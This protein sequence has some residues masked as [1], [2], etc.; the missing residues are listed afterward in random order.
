MS[1][2]FDLII[3]TDCRNQVAE[4]FLQSAVGSCI[5]THFVDFNTFSSSEQRS[6]FDLHDFLRH[7][8]DTSEQ[9]AALRRVGVCIAQRVLGEA[10]FA[11]LWQAEMPCALRIVLPS[12]HLAEN[13]LARAL[14]CLP[15]ELARASSEL[16]SLG[17]RNVHLSVAYSSDVT[18]H[19]VS[20]CVPDALPLPVIKLAPTE[21]LRILFVC[22][23]SHTQQQL[24]MRR[25]RMALQALF[26][27]QI[28]QRYMVQA[29]FLN[30]GL[31]YASLTAQL[32][33]NQGYHIIHWS[34]HGSS[35][36]LHLSKRNGAPDTLSGPELLTL[37]RLA[38]APLP[39]LFF[40]SACNSARL[41]MVHNW[42]GFTAALQ[43]K[44]IQAAAA[45]T[46]DSMPVHHLTGLAHTLLQAG[47]PSV[48]A[49][50][51][52]VGDV[53]LREWSLAFYDHLFG[54]GWPHPC[55]LAA[56][57]A[58]ARTI[59]L[60]EDILPAQHFVCDSVC[61]LLFGQATLSLDLTS[62]EAQARLLPNQ[63][64]HQIAELEATAHPYFIGRTRELSKLNSD[65]FDNRNASKNPAVL[66]LT[67]LGGMGKT[68][69]V[70]E[71]L[72]LW[73]NRFAA[74]LLYQGKP[75]ALSFEACLQDIHLKLLE[76]RPAYQAH[77][78]A[79]P[80]DAVY[81]AAPVALD[82]QSWREQRVAALIRA[83]R[84]EPILLLF[85]NF[86]SNLQA[87]SVASSLGALSADDSELDTK[88]QWTCADP[89]WDGGLLL[90][91]KELKGSPSK[92]IITSRQPPA[93]L[94]QSTK[95][96]HHILLGPLAANEAA[97]YLRE[98]PA[99][100]QM[101]MGGSADNQALAF[102]LLNASR[103]HPLLMDRFA[104]L[105]NLQ[106]NQALRDLLATLEAG[107]NFNLLPSLFLSEKGKRSALELAYLADAL[108]LSID[109][110][111]D[112]VS[113]DARRLLWLIALARQ[114]VPSSMLASVWC[115]KESQYRQIL[116]KINK[117][118]LVLPHLPAEKQA[119]VPPVS[120]DMRRELATLPPEPITRLAPT[121]LLFNLLTLGLA[122]Q[123]DNLAPSATS[124]DG[125]ISCHEL[126]RERILAWMVQH[127]A[128]REQFDEISV[129]QMWAEHL[130]DIFQSLRHQQPLAA[131]SAGSQAIE[132]CIA[133]GDFERMTD[134]AGQ[135]IT[136]ASEPRWLHRLLPHM[137][138]A[139]EAAP[140]GPLRW[141]CLGLL[142]DALRGAGKTDAS[143]PLYR[144]AIQFAR[145]ASQSDALTVDTR[146]EMAQA[147][148]DLGWLCTNAAAAARRCGDLTQARQ[149]YLDS[150]RAKQY[151]ARPTI[152]CIGTELEV[153]RID[154][155]Q[156][157]LSE[158]GMELARLL[159]QITAWWQ[160]LRSGIVVPQAPSIEVLA[161][162]LISALDIA[163][164]LD[165]AR[166]DWESALQHI[167]SILEI[168]QIMQRTAFDLAL[169]KLN[170]A[171][172]LI[173][174]QHYAQAR[175]DLETC[176]EQ[177]R[178][179]LPRRAKALGILAN[180]F[181]E[182][183]DFAQAIIQ[184]R[185]AAL[186]C[187]QLPSPAEHATAHYNLALY[188]ANSSDLGEQE[189]A[190]LHQ[191]AAL[192]YQYVGEMEQAR[193]TSLD[194]Y[195]LQFQQAHQANLALSVPRLAQ[196]L[197]LADCA[198]LRD[199][200]Q[201]H[202]LDLGELQDTLDQLLADVLRQ[203]IDLYTTHKAN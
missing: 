131:L 23:E 52:A 114:P 197:A 185:R 140:T 64:L 119:L 186:L 133:A 192:V 103:F 66:L 125:L 182:Q 181:Y 37:F 30:H 31:T 173:H 195:G 179:D 96:C 36:L 124:V 198:A 54:I 172:V 60:D 180:L 97:L 72:S 42:Q 129:Y 102:R 154:I 141:R 170:R 9:V 142:A 40:L 147:W 184:Q 109:H 15:W 167:Q 41:G 138:R 20:I 193:Q 63:R 76:N 120:D 202:T 56:S 62:C 106:N 163:S 127:A 78:Q 135:V 168:E 118:L 191:L 85:D 137:M 188:L 22:A 67:G 61:P 143:L 2:H 82:G 26:E 128:E 189:E 139:V 10:I 29:D 178:D 126:V 33:Q 161:R 158:A 86:E 14:A 88:T 122:N 156:N 121:A 7:Y 157:R 176:L 89:A 203:A 194:Q 44:T 57:L 43:G 21:P 107:K 48:L 165:F 164:D 153:L 123:H 69:L 51:F 27:Q 28:C 71:L 32:E 49:M 151:A 75:N 84:A 201:Q 55:Q 113:S 101:V 16:P 183:Q 46:A 3:Q 93:L 134:F 104:R 12:T 77:L 87:T 95:L 94:V 145:G 68:A 144:L 146:R 99:L 98:H 65:F 136:A 132:Y 130:A 150:A 45:L 39:R 83:M 47:V 13:S 108:Q 18:P 171:I 92:V 5:A 19:A 190:R 155:V 1:A 34:G 24:S 73:Q 159:P 200:L 111:L 81:C 91:A 160:Q 187:W 152:D 149:L 8:V 115:G 100:S 105:A 4:F 166:E 6:L 169:T 38:R 116:R 74:V 90:L 70:A 148:T 58:V 196:V 117:M 199:W 35:E 17:E 177:F 162:T 11:H 53:Y 174:L 80:D 110:L 79:H 59:L 112:K 25:E 175:S 50:R